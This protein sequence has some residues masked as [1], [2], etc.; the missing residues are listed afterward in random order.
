MNASSGSRPFRA[1]LRLS[2]SLWTARRSFQP[3]GP[4][5]TGRF[6]ALRTMVASVNSLRVQYSGKS[7]SKPETSEVSSPSK[8]LRRSLTY[9]E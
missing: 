7:S 8:P 4:V 3:I 5:H 6:I 2:M 1:A 9:T